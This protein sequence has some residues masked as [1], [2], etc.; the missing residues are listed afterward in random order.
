[1]MAK[2]IIRMAQMIARPFTVHT[3]ADLV[4][5]P[6]FALFLKS[7]TN[8]PKIT[9][10]TAKMRQTTPKAYIAV[11]IESLLPIYLPKSA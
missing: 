1:M 10:S 8:N 5:N 3:E 9:T 7:N 4:K 2:I 11:V 6:L